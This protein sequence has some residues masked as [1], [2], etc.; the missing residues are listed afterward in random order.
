MLL[1][2]ESKSAKKKDKSSKEAKEQQDHPNEKINKV[3]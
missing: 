2:G 1:A 3:A